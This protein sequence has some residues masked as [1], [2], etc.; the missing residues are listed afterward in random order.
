MVIIVDLEEF[1]ARTSV[2]GFASYIDHTLLK[3]VAD[4]KLLEK[5]I[6]DTRRY[7]FKSLVLPLSLISKAKEIAGN[8]IRYATVIGFPLGNTS[9]DVKVYE[10]MKAAELGVSE[11]DMV[12]NIN[13]LKSHDYE[14][15][16]RDIREVVGIAKKNNI[17]IVKVIIET[18]LL[19]D[20]EKI[21][22][23]KLVVESGADYVKTSTGFL[24][25]G[26]TIHD[27]KLLYRVASNRVKVKASGGIRHAYDT[28]ALI[29]AGASRIGTSSG[30]KIIE[31]YMSLR[32]KHS[33]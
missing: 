33:L 20:E 5:Y 15:V 31:E 7:R 9:T 24:G 8:T 3:P 6:E 30:D 1:L 13:C 16:L 4:Y 17:E 26:A 2:G 21:K 19:S 18:S 32:E 10:T 28:I 23:T 27:V 29:L 25:G 14:C 11:I 22:A 12:M